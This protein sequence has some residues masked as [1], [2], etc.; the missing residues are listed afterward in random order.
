[1]AV[2]AAEGDAVVASVGAEADRLVRD[3]IR[4][5]R[6]GTPPDGPRV[7]PELGGCLDAQ[8]AQGLPGALDLVWVH[9]WLA[10]AAHH[11][12]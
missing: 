2:L 10:L 1:M 7:P 12:Q 3:G 4:E 9:E 6:P 5:L 11:P 8:R